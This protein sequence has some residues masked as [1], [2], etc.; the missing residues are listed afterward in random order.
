MIAE[1][2]TL[3]VLVRFVAPFV[4]RNEEK[5]ARKL[6]GFASTE[7]GSALDMLKAA[8]LTDDPKLRR[9][10][11]RHAM[12]EARHAQMFRAAARRISSDSDTRGRHAGSEY[13]LI[14]ATRQN[15]F[16]SMGLVR[17]IA[18]VYLAERRG[19]L[20]F[21]ALREHFAD[22]PELAELFARI[23]KD[24]KFHVAYSKK[25]L[26]DWTKQGR[27]REVMQ[28][29]WY[30][31]LTRARDA[32]LRAGRILGDVLSRVC[33]SIIYL[34][35]LPPFVILSR[36]RD[37]AQRGWRARKLPTSIAAARRQF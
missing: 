20:Q 30:V 34:L 18:F 12:D 28:A 16:E 10:F 33:M 14:H 25:L 31:R 5:I 9:L 26:R 21:R 29:L 2:S 24:E 13:N 32:W 6:D 8:E 36:W 23:G 37:P 17:F 35:V 22:R 7:A 3:Q 15:L 11:F 1:A 19:E 4:W 27:G